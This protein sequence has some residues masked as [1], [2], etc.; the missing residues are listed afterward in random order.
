MVGAGGRQDAGRRGDVLGPWS[1]GSERVKLAG[2][3][4][5]TQTG[6]AEPGCRESFVAGEGRA[7]AKQKASLALFLTDF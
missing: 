5:E 6:G 1:W 7:K 3:G 2:C 4:A